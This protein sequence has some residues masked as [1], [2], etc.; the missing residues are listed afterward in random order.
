MS[1]IRDRIDER[2]VLVVVEEV[3]F[4]AEA[5][6]Q[7][8]HGLRDETVGVEQLLQHLVGVLGGRRLRGGPRRRP[9][10]RVR[11][12]P[13]LLGPPLGSRLQPE[14]LFDLGDELVDV[15][16]QEVA[17]ARDFGRLRHHARVALARHLGFNGGRVYV[18]G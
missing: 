4:G 13:R 2:L 15:A 16:G 10:R 18:C 1:S 11:R 5:L 6:A 9:L 17:R 3:P 7:A 8:A 14:V 12:R